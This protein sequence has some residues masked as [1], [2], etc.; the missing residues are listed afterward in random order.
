MTNYRVRNIV[1]AVVLAMLAAVFTSFYVTNYKHTVQSGEDHVDVYVAAKNIPAGTSGADASEQHLLTRKTITKGAV[2]PGAISDPSEISRSVATNDVLAGEQITS[3]RFVNAGETGVLGQLKGTQRAIEVQGD[4]HQLLAGTLKDGDRVDLVGN[5]KVEV[6]S[7][8][9]TSL[10]FDRI[11]LRDLLVLTAPVASEG[12]SGGLGGGQEFSIM[13]AVSDSQA[14]KFWFTMR[15]ADAA[16]GDG[17]GWSLLARPKRNPADT[18]E[19]IETIW[20][21]LSDGLTYGQKR[22]LAQGRR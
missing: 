7:G 11:V 4:S 13:L 17:H 3:R 15:N 1:I 5:F 6:G 19:N 16:N 22:R 18:A 20:T 12:S 9:G 8:G 14:S 2:V 10:P 21:V